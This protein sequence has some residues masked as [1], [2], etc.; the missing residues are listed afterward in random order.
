ISEIAQEMNFKPLQ[1]RH[2]ATL[3]AVVSAALLA[4]QKGGT[5]GL[6]LWPLFGT[7]NQLMGALSLL[8]ISVWLAKQ[9]KPTIYTVLPMLFMFAVSGWALVGNLLG[10]VTRGQWHLAIIGGLILGLELF[11]VRE[12]VVH[13]SG[14]RHAPPGSGGVAEA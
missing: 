12:V 2:P 11:M 8:V 10:Y 14:Y 9:G 3:L 4:M 5:G 6:A 7:A 1:S 13:M